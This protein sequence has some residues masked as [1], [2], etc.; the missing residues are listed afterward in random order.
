MDPEEF[1]KLIF[2]LFENM[3]ML[4]ELTQ[5]THDGGI[6]LIVKDPR[7]IVGGVFVVQCKRFKNT[8]SSSIIRDL[9]GVVTHLRANKGIL[10]TTG[11][12][13]AEAHAF[14]EGKPIELIDGEKLLKLLEKYSVYKVN[15]LTINA[16]TY[17][18][19]PKESFK[20]LLTSEILKEGRKENENNSLLAI[21]GVD[22]LS[23]MFILNLNNSSPVFIKGYPHSNITDCINSIIC[24]LL[25]T[26]TPQEVKMILI[27]PKIVEL[28]IYN[29]VPHLLTPV[30]TNPKTA[31]GILNWAVQEMTNR[32]NL[33]AQCGV[34]DIDSYN[35]KY[36]EA[37][38]YKI[39]IV[40][41]EL[42]DLIM[43]SSAETWEYIVKLAQKAWN[44]GIYL[45][46][47]TSSP[48]DVNNISKLG[49][50]SKII[51]TSKN[52]M[53]LDLL[54]VEKQI[55]IN[56]LFI[57]K[58]E[59]E[60]L[61]F[62]L[63]R[64]MNSNDIEFI[65]DSENNVFQSCEEDEL[66]KDAISVILETGQASISMLQRKLRIGYARAA[67]LIDQLEQLG[68]ISGYDGTKPRQ[69]LMTKDEIESF[70]KKRKTES[71]ES[72]ESIESEI[73]NT[74]DDKLA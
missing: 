16:D 65:T 53:L 12:I 11:T 31:A 45:I 46:I 1:E 7:E 57:S 51:F 28:N 43:L 61:L 30:V 67:M 27:D 47:A 38:L 39:V 44:V 72:D 14:A 8:V 26:K 34:Q 64:E 22:E 55:R 62:S 48:D 49:Y 42:S 9:Y 19:Q 15:N 50:F 17:E 68:V 2:T 52:T 18:S 58:E 71:I 23:H 10:I 4:P 24:S 33:L 63:K 21:I 3:G 73:K 20:F 6:D 66:L 59:M 32:Y 70:F 36:K 60:K 56:G 37:S 29:G 5:R 74:D 40:I 54:G 35:E 41:N 13:S 25:I 69:I